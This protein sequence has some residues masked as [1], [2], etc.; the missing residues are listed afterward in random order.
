MQ[1]DGELWGKRKEEKEAEQHKQAVRKQP[2]ACN[3]TDEK[4]RVISSQRKCKHQ[5]I[6]RAKAM[7]RKSLGVFMLK[8]CRNTWHSLICLM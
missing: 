8:T 2:K 4:V 5:G 3:L 6:K 1:I 7:T